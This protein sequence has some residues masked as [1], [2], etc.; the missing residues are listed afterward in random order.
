MVSSSIFLSFF[1]YKQIL[2]TSYTIVLA[3]Y[4]LALIYYHE[5][6]PIKKKK[7]TIEL[8]IVYLLEENK[9]GCL[10]LGDILWR[11]NLLIV[12]YLT[13]RGRFGF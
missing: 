8:G 3:P 9:L 12:V 1:T 11:S 2:C 6:L 4:F 13:F 10:E 5:F 7:K